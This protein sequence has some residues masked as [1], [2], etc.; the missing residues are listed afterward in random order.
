MDSPEVTPAKTQKS[1]F[2]KRSKPQQSQADH[3]GIRAEVK[4]FYQGPPLEDDT[5]EINWVEWQPPT[6]PEA[7][8]VKW[9]GYA[10]Q[11]YKT[12]KTGPSFGNVATFRVSSISLLSPLIKDQ[13]GDVL[14]Y[15]GAIWDTNITSIEWPLEPL[16]FAREKVAELSKTVNEA[17][18]QVHMETLCKVINDE[19]GPT[20]DELEDL[21]KDNQITHALVWTL[22]P[23]GTIVVEK[24][25]SNRNIQRAYRVTHSM[26]SIQRGTSFKAKVEYVKF[27]GVRYKLEPKSIVMPF[28]EGKKLISSLSFYP[29]EFASNSGLL[30]EQLCARGER[31][32]DFQGIEYVRYQNL[33]EGDQDLPGD[34][35][36]DLAR[37]SIQTRVIVDIF[38]YN[39]GSHPSKGSSPLPGYKGVGE[40]ESAERR[41]PSEDL[42]KESRDIVCGNSEYLLIMSPLLNGY[43][44]SSKCWETF[45]INKI[46]PLR[47]TDEAYNH[48]VHP[49]RNKDLVVSLVQHHKD[50]PKRSD[51]VIAGKGR[52]LLVLLSG[53]PGTGKTL[54]AEAIADKTR[55]PLYYVD[56][57]EMGTPHLV[58]SSFDHIMTN[59]AEWNAIVLLDEADIY[60]QRRSENGL[61]RNEIVATLLRRLEYYSG[62]MF[63]TT[64]L[65]DTIDVAVESRL[66]I[67]LRFPPLPFSSRTQIWTNFLNR[68]PPSFHSNISPA[69]INELALWTLNGRDIKNALKMTVSWCQHHGGKV[70]FVALEDVIR[71]TC[72]RARKETLKVN[73]NG[74]YGVNGEMDVVCSALSHRHEMEELLDL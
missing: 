59:A 26:G 62:I 55:L 50:H 32:L 1:R 22:F 70:T 7:K 28:F 45:H 9:E 58:N 5:D 42:K 2:F 18:A 60:L 15:H 17:E 57:N 49:E 25:S 72:P 39:R 46:F 56:A 44:L 3:F 29:I 71:A 54:M 23:K 74:E 53:P 43:S 33:D 19:L 31:T 27:D 40:K 20:I 35:E 73:G 69:N 6:L 14:E 4:T 24:D 10:I 8:K 66:H 48:L 30:K 13:L 11:I 41:R 12:Q 38:G 34:R 47:L 63:L 51:D 37:N 52:G 61:T 67:H 68:L 16:Y 36:N 64:N 65:Y 21:E